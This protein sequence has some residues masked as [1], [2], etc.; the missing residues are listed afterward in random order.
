[1][2]FSAEA[3]PQASPPSSQDG[4]S[5]DT[6]SIGPDL[7]Q[8]AGSPSAS[9]PPASFGAKAPPSPPPRALYVLRDSS[10]LNYNRPAH[11]HPTTPASLP[12]SPPPPG[13]TPHTPAA[14]S[15]SA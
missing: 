15:H 13:T 3:P 9:T 12:H 14:K 6:P 4:C 7:P 8:T 5:P 2:G 11:S 10:R 1:H